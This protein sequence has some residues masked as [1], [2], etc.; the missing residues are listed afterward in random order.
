MIAMDHLRFFNQLQLP[1]HLMGTRAAA[2]LP[3]DRININ[4]TKQD[5]QH[6]NTIIDS[7]PL[8]SKWKGPMHGDQKLEVITLQMA[9]DEAKARVEDVAAVVAAE[10]AVEVQLEVLIQKDKSMEHRKSG[11]GMNGTVD[12]LV[13]TAT[14]TT[15]HMHTRPK[16]PPPQQHVAQTAST[17]PVRTIGISTSQRLPTNTAH[18]KNNSPT[19]STA[20]P[21]APA[22]R[23]ARNPSAT[24][25]A[26]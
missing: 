9:V 6:L 26:Y 21:A 11:K 24:Q 14:T 8:P 12:L 22:K 1:H 5:H 19:A 7:L 13:Q 17:S 2:R 16:P 18:L 20:D 4:N 25:K 15:L 23:P 3:M 10:V